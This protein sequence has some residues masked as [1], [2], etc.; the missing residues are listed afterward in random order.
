MRRSSGASTGEPVT[1]L[2]PIL[3]CIVIAPLTCAG[4]TVTL[5]DGT[6][7]CEGASERTVRAKLGEPDL[8]E[9]AERFQ[10]GTPWFL[11]PETDWYYFDRRC[12]VNFRSGGLDRASPITS[13]QIPDLKRRQRL[14]REVVP[15]IAPGSSL[16]EVIIQLGQPGVVEEYWIEGGHSYVRRISYAELASILPAPKRLACYFL[17]HDIAVWVDD[18]RVRKAEP[19]TLSFW[20][21]T[22]HREP[23]ETGPENG[24]PA[25]S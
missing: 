8:T 5:P 12:L 15:L 22:L 1:C 7:F 2:N 13:A 10:P 17:S 4:C 24:R 16:A 11:R 23:P 21:D 18:G 3:L 25:G 19:I 20:K 14:Y 6:A 9:R